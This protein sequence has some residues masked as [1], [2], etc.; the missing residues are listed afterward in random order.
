MRS[1]FLSISLI[2][3]ALIGLG[4]VS[5]ALANDTASMP[6]PSSA[7]AVAAPDTLTAR[8][9]LRPGQTAEIAAGMSGKLTSA[10][11]RAGQYFKKGAVLAKFNCTRQEAELSA[12]TRAHQTLSLKHQ[13]ISEL[14]N[15]GAAGEFELTIAQSE[16]NQAAAERDVIKARLSDCVVTAPFAGYVSLQHV[17]AFETP[18][19]NAPL[20]SIL[21]AGSLEVSVIAPSAWMRW[22]KSGTRFDFTVDETGQSF[23]AKVVR[24]GAAVDP[25]SQTI[26]L[27]ARPT[28]KVGRSLAG[29]S[30]V[31]KFTP[32]KEATAPAKPQNQKSGVK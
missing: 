9:V 8:G 25:V 17:A 30:G 13:N 20:Y 3:S 29:M 21:K 7:E 4:T 6:M 18:A 32:P 26:E 24:T 14:Y 23:K 12:L 2:T 1:H 15:A 27:T 28:G 16:M 22:V 19:I 10:P 11:Y 31:A 5:P